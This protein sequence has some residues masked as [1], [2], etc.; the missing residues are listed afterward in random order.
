MTAVASLTQTRQ[1][2]M[3]VVATSIS[4][5]VAIASS[6]TTQRLNHET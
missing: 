5:D 2:K 4:P 3:R 1:V 6:V